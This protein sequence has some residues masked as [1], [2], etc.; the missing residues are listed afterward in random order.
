MKLTELDPQFITYRDTRWLHHVDTAAEAQGIIFLCPACFAKNA[1]PVGTHAIEVSFNNRGV[2]PG[3][4][5]HNSQ[6]QP[7]RWNVSGTGYA[8]LTLT[9]SI[10]IDCWHGFV[11]NGEVK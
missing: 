1:G 7:S 6:G 9:P 3:Q 10:L 8:D 4:G 11:T 2:S 5:S